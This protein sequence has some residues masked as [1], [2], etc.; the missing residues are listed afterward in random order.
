[1]LANPVLV[2][3]S[4]L[5]YNLYLWHTLIELWLIHHHLPPTAAVDP[6]SDEAWKPWYLGIAI[7]SS[8]LISAAVTYFVERPLLE[9]VRPHRFAFPWRRLIGGR[10]SAA[11]LAPAQKK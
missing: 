7:P 10:T 8:F 3:I 2:F 1:V 11:V 4:V 6:H 5:S 9:T